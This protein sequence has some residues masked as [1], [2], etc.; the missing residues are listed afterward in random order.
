VA[1]CGVVTALA[2]VQ[3]AADVRLVWINAL[4][5]NRS[6]ENFVHKLALDFQAFW[7]RSFA[8]I[9]FSGLKPRAAA[10][11]GAA[12]PAAAVTP[13]KAPAAK[14]ATPQPKKAAAAPAPVASPVAPAS[15]E[16]PK[17]IHIHSPLLSLL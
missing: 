1:A 13:A 5:Y 3:F 10:G 4:T 11:A 12:S 2:R 9:D 7:E 6:P 17:V 8:K 14:K 16:V 15:Q